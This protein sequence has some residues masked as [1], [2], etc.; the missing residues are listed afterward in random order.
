MQELESEKKRPSRE[1]CVCVCVRVRVC[2]CI[3]A[4]VRVCVCVMW[5]A[6]SSHFHIGTAFLLCFE[7]KWH[8]VWDNLENHN[9]CLFFTITAWRIMILLQMP[10]T[11]TVSWCVC[12]HD[13]YH[14]FM[15]CEPCNVKFIENVPG[16]KSLPHFDITGALGVE[17]LTS[18]EKEV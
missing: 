10:C 9:D 11:K 3:R 15:C 5:H 13:N 8:Q 16:E 1:V 17:K 6:E 7:T 2:V 14:L 4:C 18:T 12:V